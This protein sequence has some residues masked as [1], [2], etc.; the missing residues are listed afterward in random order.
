[1]VGEMPSLIGSLAQ[2]EEKMMMEEEKPPAPLPDLAKLVASKK[3]QQTPE[4][5]QMQ[6]ILSRMAEDNPAAV[7]E[8]IQMWLG[9]DK[10]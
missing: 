9:E 1:M 2:A 6:R 7:A 4:E 5:E 10:R 8:I 3:Q